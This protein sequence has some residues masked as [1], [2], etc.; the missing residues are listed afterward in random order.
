MP[1]A[2][3]EASPQGK[4]RISLTISPELHAKA[5]RHAQNHKYTDFSGMVTQ[6]LVDELTRHA[7]ASVDLLTAEA[8]K[9]QKKKPTDSGESNHDERK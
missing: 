6:L 9:A 5:V 4:T 3:H 7:G 1:K 8:K 2:Q